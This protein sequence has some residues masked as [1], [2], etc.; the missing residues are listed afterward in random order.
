MS[1]HIYQ[2]IFENFLTPEQTPRKPHYAKGVDFVLA[3]S[4]AAASGKTTFC[5]D[6]INYLAKQ[7]MGAVHV[8]LDGYLLDR[9]TR[10]QKQLS[11]YDPRSSDLPKMI[12][13]ETT[14]RPV[15]LNP[16]A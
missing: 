7:K 9:K 1:S 10:R 2:Y 12:K 16:L 3:I 15:V 14:N 4:G 11:G 5:Q 6:M 8:P 13:M